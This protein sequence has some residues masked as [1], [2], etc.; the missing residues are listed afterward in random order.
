MSNKK[1][2]IFTGLS[3]CTLFA[4]QNLHAYLLWIGQWE[5]NLDKSEGFEFDRFKSRI[6]VLVKTINKN[7][8]IFKTF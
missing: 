5:K 6:D 2:I 4:V 3:Y 8:N 7:H 1:I